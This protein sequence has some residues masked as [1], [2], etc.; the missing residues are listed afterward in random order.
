MYAWDM[1]LKTTYYM[2]TMAA[3]QVEKSTVQI[4]KYGETHNRAT[5]T[6]AAPEASTP[7]QPVPAP[8]PA[9]AKAT[10]SAAVMAQAVPQCR[11]DDPDCDSCGG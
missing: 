10:V 6:A 11:I 1:G 2:R 3:S 4:S 5:G 7:A 8:T 9:A